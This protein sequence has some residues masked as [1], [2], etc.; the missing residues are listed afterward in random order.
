MYKAHFVPNYSP[1]WGHLKM[2]AHGWSNFVGG[3]KPTFTIKPGSERIPLP[4]AEP[5]KLRETLDLWFAHAYD[6]GVPFGLCLLG[7][8]SVMG[9]AAA[10]G[11]RLYLRCEG[12]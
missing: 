7:M 10:M 4:D 3:E 2:A 12:S 6:A 5:E 9:A 8:T 1:A 11:W